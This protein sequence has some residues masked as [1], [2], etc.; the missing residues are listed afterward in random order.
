AYTVTY[1]G[2]ETVEI[3]DIEKNIEVVI[4]PEMDNVEVVEW[5]SGDT[6]YYTLSTTVTELYC[7]IEMTV[8]EETDWSWRYEPGFTTSTTSQYVEYYNNTTTGETIDSLTFADTNYIF[9][10][11]AAES[12]DG[13][14][15]TVSLYEVEDSEAVYVAANEVSELDDGSIQV[16]TYIFY[17]KDSENLNEESMSELA[18]EF[19]NIEA[20]LDGNA[21]VIPVQ[22]S[23]SIMTVNS[24]GTITQTTTE[25]ID[26]YKI[27]SY[28]EVHNGEGVLGTVTDLGTGYD[29]YL[30]DYTFNSISEVTVSDDAT[31]AT[32]LVY[33]SE[34]YLDKNGSDE[35]SDWT[36]ITYTLYLGSS[37]YHASNPVYV[38]YGTQY[39]NYISYMNYQ[40]QTV[41]VLFDNDQYT[42]HSDFEDD[43]L[44][45]SAAYYYDENGNKVNKVLFDDEGELAEATYYQIAYTPV[46]TTEGDYVY[47][48]NGDLVYTET[49]I[50]AFQVL[51]VAESVAAV[52]FDS[53]DVSLDVFNT[54]T[55]EYWLDDNSLVENYYNP[56]EYDTE[57]VD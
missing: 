55:N 56:I 44:L 14:R 12:G 9:I 5:W 20:Y 30:T 43:I 25:E 48:T 42:E 7:G 16:V 10:E 13:I 11:T 54:L 49:E 32:I 47:D 57:E 17:V 28:D 34:D 40:N 39:D 53:I 46:Q 6:R 33:N 45:Y 27:I 51:E 29:Y 23:T 24:D 8:T 26:S 36:R 52:E 18:K 31:T 19:K 1:A 38:E 41:L 37:L 4:D 3:N 15:T 22:I 21:N 50:Y 35:Y 2:Y